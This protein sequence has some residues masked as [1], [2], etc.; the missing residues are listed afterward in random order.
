MKTM[1]AALLVVTLTA[2]CLAAEEEVTIEQ[3]WADP[4]RF[5][6]QTL[7]FKGVAVAGKI[8]PGPTRYRVTVKTPEGK[9]IDSKLRTEGIT[10]AIPKEQ[11]GMLKGFKPESFYPVTL[12]C[13][14]LRSEKEHWMAVITNLVPAPGTLTGRWKGKYL[15]GTEGVTWLDLVETTRGEFHGT[16]NSDKGTA[17]IQGDRAKTI[18]KGTSDYGSV[19]VT[20]SGKL[21][22]KGKSLSLSWSWTEKTKKGNPKTHTREAIY[23]PELEAPSP[24]SSSIV[25]TPKTLPD[26]KVGAAYQQK[27]TASGGT[28]PY[29][30]FTV[31]FGSLPAGLTLSPEGE[32]SGSPTASGNF[33]FT[34]S[35]TDSRKT[36]EPQKGTQN[37][38][39]TVHPEKSIFITPTSLPNGRV[40]VEYRVD[41]TAKGGTGPYTFA[42]PE[43]SKLPEGLSLTA[44][45]VL[46]GTPTARGT[47][48]FAIAVQDA[49]KEGPNLD[50]W[51]YTLTVEP[52]IVVSP[53]SGPDAQVQGLEETHLHAGY[54]QTFAASGGRPPYKFSI[55]SGKPPEGM[56]LSPEGVLSGSPTAKGTY[57]FTVTATESGAGSEPFTGSQAYSL[58][59]KREAGFWGWV[60]D[61]NQRWDSLNTLV[62]GGFGLLTVIVLGWIALKVAWKGDKKKDSPEVKPTVTLTEVAQLIEGK[63]DSP[64]APKKG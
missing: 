18:L 41:L 58:T 10:F 19:K 22:E 49:R 15:K 29:Q 42:L 39:L 53:S 25:L 46:R 8:D 64:D 48:R 54:S 23:E 51:P 61:L 5:D 56:S 31:S 63:K 12:T 43:G 57:A 21:L 9:V 27:I 17:P 45:G 11:A 36:P 50:T 59:V 4:A 30:N 62:K 47:S 14:I 20:V 38:R 52:N 55:S 1:L 16:W 40:E 7:V 34:V 44:D 24:A 3:V 35:G 37:Y 6:G 33:F 13:K 2:L 26:A 32:L 28:A 60:A